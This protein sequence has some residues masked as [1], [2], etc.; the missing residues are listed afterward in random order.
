MLKRLLSS[1]VFIVIAAFALR[2]LILSVTWHKVAPD[3]NG[4]PY[5]YEVGNIARSIASGR[6]FSSPFS[7][8]TTGPTAWL[9]PIY[10][11]LVAA[12]FKVWGNFTTRSFFIIKVLN[13]LFASFV[14]LPIYTVA[15]QS[16]SASIAILASWLWVILPTAWYIPVTDIW[17]STLATLLFAFLFSM[18]LALCDLPGQKRQLFVYGGLWA[19]AALTS[20]VLLSLFPFFLVWIAW[21]SK[22]RSSLWL[23]PLAAAVL[24]FAVCLLP[25][26][27]RNYRAFGKFIPVRSNFG[28]ELWLGNNPDAMDV[29]SFRLHPL[30]NQSEANKYK[31]L[32]EV[33]Y[34]RMKLD[35][36]IAFMSA[37]PARTLYFIMRRFGTNWFAVSD[38]V[39]SIFST[40]GLYLKVYF[41]ANASMILL[42]WAGVVLMWRAQ[43]HYRAPYLFVLLIY[44]LV[45]YLTHTLVRYRFPMDPILTILAAFT[46]V[47]TIRSVRRRKLGVPA[48]AHSQAVDPT[49]MALEQ[50]GGFEVIIKQELT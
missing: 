43:H 21:V 34:V 23:Q 27:L 12:I 50:K 18:T 10:P 31:T 2:I 49:K 14:V 35:E 36:A 30:W 1:P 16:F 3:A 15:R 26:T 4:T 8:V 19:L 42:S 47:C 39:Q 7:L 20:P 11:S 40:G 33:A 25:W 45:F 24:V 44:P 46:V 6:G 13:C 38:R 37:H 9:G 22:K 28:V 41:L 17:D 29:N 48:T 5:G 32:G